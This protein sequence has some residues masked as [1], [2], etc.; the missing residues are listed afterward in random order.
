MQADA[1]LR[2]VTFGATETVPAVESS[3][4]RELRAPQEYRERGGGALQQLSRFYR[5]EIRF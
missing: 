5:R 3:D 4:I 1:N 2:R